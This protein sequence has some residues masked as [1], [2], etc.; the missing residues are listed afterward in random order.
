MS[1]LMEALRKAEQ[2][3]KEAAKR[4]REQRKGSSDSGADQSDD[5]KLALSLEDNSQPSKPVIAAEHQ[6]PE[7]DQLSVNAPDLTLAPL[8]LNPQSLAAEEASEST[9]SETPQTERSDEDL[10]AEYL[11]G[12]TTLTEAFDAVE[13]T[14][15]TNT[16]PNPATSDDETQAHDIEQESDASVS[17]QRLSLENTQQG[18]TTKTS[19]FTDTQHGTMQDRLYESTQAEKI[20]QK[21]TRDQPVRA[22]GPATADAVFAAKR[23][24]NYTAYTVVTLISLI[25]VGLAA[26]GV[27]YYFSVTPISRDLPS[28]QVARGVEYAEPSALEGLPETVTATARQM[29]AGTDAS[30]S[31]EIDSGTAVDEPAE[32]PVA[33][34]GEQQA[35]LLTLDPSDFDV[36]AQAVDTTPDTIDPADSSAIAAEAES[37]TAGAETTRQ[38][39]ADQMIELSPAMLKISRSQPAP[40]T[41][42]I[43]TSAWNEFQAGNMQAA[44]LLYQT[45]LAEQPDNRDALLGAAAVA[46][47]E[48]QPE[49]AFGYYIKV[50]RQ[51]PADN[52]AQAAL[53][54][55]QGAADPVR[56]ES[57][58]KQMLA[59][60]P[61]AAYLYFTL[62]NLY[63]TQ[64]RWPDAQQAFFD[65][66]SRADDNAD[67][68]LNLAISLDR[69]GQPGAALDYYR[70]AVLLS[71]E[72][73]RSSFDV[74]SVS[75]RIQEIQER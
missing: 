41:S 26:F 72:Y 6:V 66:Y 9:Q 13:A 67:Y 3:K 1:L 37:G 52:V 74:V 47:Q 62:G 43:L 28:P 61:D 75:R 70:R 35:A 58:I 54:S 21:T 57:R 29:A 15:N 48:R 46:L 55:L 53:I 38:Q 73:Q 12:D 51:N 31:G 19:R 2:E 10:Y 50:L 27:F 22:F 18:S 7:R 25:V 11:K 17:G 64:L 42:R 60:D 5:G 68:A 69:L 33:D 16:H 23:P 34:N 32:V 59:R 40:V 8:V 56:H 20:H 65:A 63:A 44:R 39:D 45:A 36:A 14:H 24:P 49:V 4:L 71:E 30:M